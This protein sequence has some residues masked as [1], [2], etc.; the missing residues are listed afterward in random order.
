MS[1]SLPDLNL[2]KVDCLCLISLGNGGARD[3]LHA[4]CGVLRALRTAPKT[5]QFDNAD[6]G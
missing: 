3:E 4:Q 6:R 1:S 2:A 5:D